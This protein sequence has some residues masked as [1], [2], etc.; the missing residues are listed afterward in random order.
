M[1][2]QQIE[3][4][5]RFIFKDKSKPYKVNLIQENGLKRLETDGCEDLKVFHH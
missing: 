1:G 2:L 4:L 3:H 5:E